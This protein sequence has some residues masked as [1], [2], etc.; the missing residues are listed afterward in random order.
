MQDETL[1]EGVLNR[2]LRVA[3]C[4]CVAVCA[5]GCA[6]LF[7][8]T[9]AKVFVTSS[10]EGAGVVVVGG[11]VGDVLIKGQQ[12]SLIAQSF[13]SLLVE[14]VDE[15]TAEILRQADMRE[16]L[17][18]LVIFARLD[19][20]PEHVPPELAAAIGLIPK[21]VILTALSLVGVED[22]GETPMV[23]DLGLGSSYIVL[24]FLD[25][26]RIEAVEI[27]TSFNHLVWLN[28][29][30]LGL[31]VIVDVISGAWY[32]VDTERLTIELKPLDG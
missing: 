32:E 3:L 10:P 5:S 31:G 19:R 30:N 14:S 2:F 22:Y 1:K 12:A 6:T 7:T 13:V 24:T 17:T 8:G 27:E 20:L 11:P 15:D 9:S 28:I 23:A 26:H 16:L 4:V 18:A 29:F 25:D 21:P